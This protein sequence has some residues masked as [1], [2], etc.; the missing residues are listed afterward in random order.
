MD[1]AADVDDDVGGWVVGEVDDVGTDGVVVSGEVVSLVV[2]VVDVG[3]LWTSVRGTQVYDGSG[4][5]PG[6]TTCV[7]GDGD[8]VCG[9]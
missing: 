9:R 7:A 3:S 8:S 6:G 1:G 4:T 5:K 2:G